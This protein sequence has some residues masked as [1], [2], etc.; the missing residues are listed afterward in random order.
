MKQVKVPVHNPWD[1]RKD[2]SRRPSEE[3]E[4]KRILQV[5]LRL[6]HVQDHPRHLEEYQENHRKERGIESKY[7][8]WNDPA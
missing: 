4:P 7:R 6:E 2:Q 8:V 5:V 1:A 3:K